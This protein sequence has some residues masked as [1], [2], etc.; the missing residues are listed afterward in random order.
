MRMA[1]EGLDI[2]SRRIAELQTRIANLQPP[3]VTVIGAS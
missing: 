2:L 3:M 1:R